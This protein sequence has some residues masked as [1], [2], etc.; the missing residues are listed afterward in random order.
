MFATAGHPVGAPSQAHS[1]PGVG[2]HEPLGHCVQSQEAPPPKSHT[3]E[4]SAHFIPAG[5][6]ASG[7]PACPGPGAGAQPVRGTIHVPAG[8][9]ASVRQLILTSSPYSHCCSVVAQ[10]VPGAGIEG[11][12]TGVGAAST[13][14]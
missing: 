9:V 2:T 1:P 6:R 14:Q 4:E 13:L 3:S 8:Q 11:G 7:Q 12:Q 10:A 5:R